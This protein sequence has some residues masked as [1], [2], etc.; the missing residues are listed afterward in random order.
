MAYQTDE[1]R[2][3]DVVVEGIAIPDAFKRQPSSK[4]NEFRQA[5]MRGA[6]PI[7]HIGGEERAQSFGRYS[8]YGNPARPEGLWHNNRRSV[9][10]GQF[11]SHHNGIPAG[12]AEIPPDVRTRR[13]RPRERSA[14]EQRYELATV[15]SITSS[16]IASSPGGTSMPSARA[17]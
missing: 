2:M 3:L 14:A 9:V 10:V 17:V 8:G 4:R 7:L 16:A 15:H 13:K 1:H 6:E 5:R 11:A 12:G